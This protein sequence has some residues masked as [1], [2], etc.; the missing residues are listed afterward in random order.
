MTTIPC[1]PCAV[2]IGHPP[3][4]QP[5]PKPPA[6]QPPPSL[7]D[8]GVVRAHSLSASPA[9][10]QPSH[11]VPGSGIQGAHNLQGSSD[12]RRS[13]THGEAE[14]EAN[15]PF[16]PRAAS[17]LAP[18][19]PNGAQEAPWAAASQQPHTN[20][21]ESDGSEVPVDSLSEDTRTGS[22]DEIEMGVVV[23]DIERGVS[24]PIAACAHDHGAWPLKG[25][26]GITAMLVRSLS[27]ASS[28]GRKSPGGAP[29]AMP[30]QAYPPLASGGTSLHS[31]T[32]GVAPDTTPP[33]RRRHRHRSPER[34]GA[35]EESAAGGSGAEGED[36]GEKRRRRRRHRSDVSADAAEGAEALAAT[37]ATGDT[38]HTRRRRHR[39]HG[40]P[41]TSA[42]PNETEN[43]SFAEDGTRRRRRRHHSPGD[44]AEG[45]ATALRE[46]PEA[47]AARRAKALANSQ[48]SPTGALLRSGI[49]SGS[50]RRRHRSAGTREAAPTGRPPRAEISEGAAAS[51][52]APLIRPTETSGG[53][54]GERRRRHRH[55]SRSLDTSPDPLAA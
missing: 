14:R 48:N 51:Q 42:M 40:E 54:D 52:S 13:K 22:D 3:P 47:R 12:L 35:G 23:S 34:T 33:R 6:P 50:R 37:P 38:E 4:P 1:C 30:L 9:A 7:V 26:A 10:L 11:S 36:G 8:N 21:E 15:R 29:A 17:W 16:R 55:H 49:E 31:L 45:D 27:K 46:T 25:G 2:K 44:R 53:G 18:Q 19:Q 39:H 43:V 28:N 32:P 5:P 20:G 41:T 24:A